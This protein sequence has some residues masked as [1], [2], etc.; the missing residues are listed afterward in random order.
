MFGLDW[1]FTMFLKA[2][3]DNFIRLGKHRA[4][5]NHECPAWEPKLKSWFAS[6]EKDNPE[7]TKTY[8]N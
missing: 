2:T 6:Y 1:I 4:C 5:R 7:K 8:E 3:E